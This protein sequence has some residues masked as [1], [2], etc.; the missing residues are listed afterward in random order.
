MATTLLEAYDELKN[1]TSL[2]Q[3]PKEHKEMIRC[4]LP[5][6]YDMNN[7]WAKAT[8]TQNPMKYHYQ[9]SRN[10]PE[11]NIKPVTNEI[12]PDESE[13][14]FQ[15]KIDPEKVELYFTRITDPKP[16][17]P[18]APISSVFQPS[19]DVNLKLDQ[20]SQK[21][22]KPLWRFESFSISD[23]SIN[24]PE[25]NEPIGGY[26]QLY[27]LKNPQPI[28]EPL[29]FEV[30]TDG[31]C[32]FGQTLVQIVHMILIRNQNIGLACFL[33]KIRKTL[34][35]PFAIALMPL[36]DSKN[37]FIASSSFETSDHSWATITTSDVY[38]AINGIINNNA[39]GYIQVRS[40]IK[41]SI[42]EIPETGFSYTWSEGK[43]E[44]LIS[45]PLHP[46]PYFPSPI[47]TV[48]NFHLT[49][50]KP[51][52]KCYLLIK[53]FLQHEQ[54]KIDKSLEGKIGFIS[55]NLKLQSSYTSSAMLSGNEITFP[56]TIRIFAN[57]QFTP[58][59]HIIFAV[60]TI[61]FDKEDSP[62]ILY[63]TGIIP[64]NSTTQR[65]QNKF[66]EHQHCQRS[67]IELLLEKINNNLN[68]TRCMATSL[69]FYQ[70]ICDFKQ[71]GSVVL[72]TLDTL[73]ALTYILLDVNIERIVLYQQFLEICIDLTSLMENV[74]FVNQL[75]NR[76]EVAQKIVSVV[77]EQKTSIYPPEI[78]CKMAMEIADQYHKL[79]TMRLKWLQEC[80]RI[81]VDN[82]DYVSAFIT[83]IHIIALSLSAYSF[84]NRKLFDYPKIKV[85]KDN[86]NH[87]TIVQPNLN[88]FPKYIYPNKQL[89]IDFSFMPEVLPEVQIE[90]E[91]MDKNS[92]G[93]LNKFTYN[94]LIEEFERAIDYGKK[95]KLYYSLRP[96]LSMEMRLVKIANNKEQL[97]KVFDNLSK[98]FD[99]INVSNVKKTLELPLSFYLIEE[100][101]SNQ[102]V[103]RSVYCIGND[104]NE[105]DNVI[106][107]NMKNYLSKQER[108]LNV[109]INICRNHNSKNCNEP[110]ICIIP[111]EPM[112]NND[113]IID[114]EFKHCW[115]KFKTKAD[116]NG[117][118]DSISMVYVTTANY[119]PHYRMYTSI[120]DYQEKIVKFSELVNDNINDYC[121][122]LDVVCKEVE[123]WFEYNNFDD[124]DLKAD[125]LFGPD[126]HKLVKVV[127]GTLEGAKRI[128]NL[129]RNNENELTLSLASKMRE[130]YVKAMQ[131]MFC[132]KLS[133]PNH[134]KF[135][136]SVNVC[137]KNVND[138]LEQY[139]LSKVTDE[140]YQGKSD[141]ANNF[142]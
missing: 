56:D 99:L 54:I 91:N 84:L 81:N 76:L 40:N 93:L 9:I 43:N 67:L 34:R 10:T 114:G 113:C 85:D 73:D 122:A 14:N 135:E 77:E 55:S 117:Y 11:I 21:A 126:A 131:M 74:D 109:P 140:P 137:F 104:N 48:S 92:L 127:S 82:N 24:V 42:S 33:Q 89:Y 8:F 68:S 16:S 83:Q 95:A 53:F 65:E 136:Q 78:N 49:F 134:D 13:K 71:N 103:I 132:C 28:S 19:V 129:L 121:D 32:A 12:H 66:M 106:N 1:E 75:N 41:I 138:F 102:Q 46:P 22:Q 18:I 27:N 20:Y 6:H 119:S 72:S 108:Y 142:F 7:S 52:K 30:V 62:M 37:E 4:L 47:I 58:N 50:A 38:T 25:L 141:R 115:N 80:L 96:I 15:M 35:I 64:L 116:L 105:D 26:I 101:Q 98:V 110:G 60:Y 29:F 90:Y 112:D 61:S 94:F 51:P 23:F 3:I 128:L 139:G 2:K 125:E 39:N 124:K 63:K 133:L 97:S 111:L 36:F 79:P 87:L 130:K 45:M 5:E 86:S 118:F 100:R 123:D 57:K 44:N 17:K 69:I 120:N 88:T 107:E 70:F 31:K 59:S